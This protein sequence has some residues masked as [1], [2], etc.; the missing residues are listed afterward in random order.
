MMASPGTRNRGD[1]GWGSIFVLGA[2]AAVL[3]VV[4]LA[5]VGFAFALNNAFKGF[6]NIGIPER[7][8][9]AAIPIPAGACPYLRQVHDKAESAGQTYFRI[10]RSLDGPADAKRWRTQA[11]RHAHA[12]APFE[13]TL[14][15]AIPHVPARVAIELRK[16]RVNVAAG[17][18]EVAIARSAHEYASASAGPVMEGFFALND[19]SDLVGT[20]CGFELSPG[21]SVPND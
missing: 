20:A 4:V 5:F 2:I 21:L 17:R 12:L 13:V 7:Q 14:R 18:R 15:A 10:L 8:H 9:L 11:A 3:A 19:A 6:R 1:R 16:V